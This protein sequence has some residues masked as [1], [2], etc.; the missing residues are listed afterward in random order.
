MNESAAPTPSVC[1][2]APLKNHTLWGDAVGPARRALPTGL[3][4]EEAQTP[5]L[6]KKQSFKRK[7]HGSFSVLEILLQKKL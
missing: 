3:C 4:K 6:T 7:G 5:N 2:T 1:S